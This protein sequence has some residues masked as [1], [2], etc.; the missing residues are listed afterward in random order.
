MSDRAREIQEG[1]VAVR[2]RIDAAARRAGRDPAQIT[3][4]A[5]SKTWPHEDIRCAYEAGQRDFGENYAQEL[6]AKRAELADLTDLRWHFIGA[7]QSNKAKLVVP[8][9]VLIHAVDRASVAQALSRRALAA[10]VAAEVLIEV[11]VS[12]EG[13]KAGVA[14]RDADVLANALAGYDG[15]HL[16]GLMCVPAADQPDAVTRA[17][18]RRLRELQARLA[19]DHPTVTRLSMGMS[20][21]FELAIEEGATHVRVGSAIFGARAAR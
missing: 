4:V 16:T 20:H 3:L 17:A 10:G 11:N 1:L 21:D 15:V 8:G 5:V 6:A 2:A 14:P 12:D 19:V 9:C 13:S 18:F 7:L